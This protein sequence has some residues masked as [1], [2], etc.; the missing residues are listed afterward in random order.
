MTIAE[1]TVLAYWAV[2]EDRDRVRFGA[3]L[4]EEIV[5]DLPQPAGREHLVERR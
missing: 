4:A 2:C 1:D 3:L 5:Y